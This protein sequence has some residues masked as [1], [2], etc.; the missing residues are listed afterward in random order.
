MLRKSFSIYGLV[1]TLLVLAMAAFPVLAQAEEFRLGVTRNF[2]YSRGDQIRG[3]IKLYIIG[4]TASIK[5]VEYL[6]D[7]KSMGTGTAPSFDLS[8]QTTD[9]P[10]GY[11]DLSA[12]IQ[13]QDGRTITVAARQFNFVTPE[14]EASGSFGIIIPVLG[15]ILVVIAV[16]VGV[17]VLLFRKKFVNMPPGTQRNY[18]MRG[19]T[20]C[21]RC[22]RPYAIHWWAFNAGIRTKFDRCDFCGKWALV[23]PKSI[24]EL[25]AAER[26]EIETSEGTAPLVEKSEDEKLRE[27]IDKSKYSD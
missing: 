1:L 20:I 18:G 17:Q 13:T 25:R 9:Y 2:G 5:S 8:F 12:A 21:P 14:E 6:I 15:I 26:R 22:K 24:E 7:G 4:S 16:I 11:H 23:G 10:T 19:G 3:S 27:M